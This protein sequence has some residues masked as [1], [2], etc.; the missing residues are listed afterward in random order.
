MKAEIGEL[1]KSYGE[2]R[3]FPENIDDIWH[4][5]H[6]IAPGDLVFATTLRTAD[7][8]TDKIR[9]EKVE[10]RPVR[11]GIRVEKVE[12]HHYAN[13][14]RVAGLIEHG[15]DQGFYH[16]LNIETGYEISVIRQWRKSDLERIDR[17]V[18]ASVY[19]VIHI[20]T[21]EE[22]EAELFRIRHFGPEPVITITMGSGKGM[23]V[24]SRS[25][26]FEKVHGQL[27]PV[28]GPLV[29]A[30][31]G[32]IKE[33][34]M[35]FFRARESEKAA[36]TVVVETR[37]TGAGAVQE[38]IGLGI[39]EK[40]A[41]DLQLAREVNLMGEFLKR[42]SKGEPVAYGRADVKNAADCGAIEE[43]LVVDT[44]IRDPEIIVLME[45]AEQS[46]AGVVVFSTGFEPGKRL[47][48]L[49]GVAALLRYRIG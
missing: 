22:G 34:F 41:G 23:E 18:K 12:F 7:S 21:I 29:V 32:F 16:T 1:Q 6:L 20:L 9:P 44:L 17:A 46:D 28:N 49:G 38:V 27:V 30:G 11:L 39:L 24:N 37:R 8:S 45:K 33:D 13:R 14:L 47:D 25:S 31:P 36:K 42:V 15:T 48:A 3:L 19:D 35:K 10:K 43:I 40:L 2:I 5:S 26:F 4:L